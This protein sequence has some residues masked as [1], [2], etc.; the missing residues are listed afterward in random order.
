MS[1]EKPPSNTQQR[2]TLIASTTLAIAATLVCTGFLISVW[3]LIGW[4]GLL[5]LVIPGYVM[6]E[7][8]ASKSRHLTYLMG[9]IAWGGS[10]LF[11]LVVAGFTYMFWALRGLGD[12]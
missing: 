6:L 2:L 1:E 12:G 5:A 10:F 8:S 9:F 7:V 11:L 3:G 4:L